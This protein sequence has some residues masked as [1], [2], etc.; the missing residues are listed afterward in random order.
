[1]RPG[2]SSNL[3]VIGTIAACMAAAQMIV[4][5]PSKKPREIPGWPILKGEQG[6]N[7][8]SICIVA[9]S[10]VVSVALVAFLAASRIRLRLG[11]NS[12]AKN[13][14]TDT[15]STRLVSLRPP[16]AP[17]GMDGRRRRVR[18]RFEPEIAG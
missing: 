18:G 8:P 9:A 3:P 13:A 16:S 5:A 4:T 15:G 6:P 7:G 11:A 14:P 17:F 10:P 1:M 2:E 12:L